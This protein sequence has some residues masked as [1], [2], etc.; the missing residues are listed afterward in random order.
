MAV[1]R[2]HIEMWS[3]S[4]DMDSHVAGDSAP[5]GVRRDAGKGFAKLRSQL[6][7]AL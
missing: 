4:M 7:P 2:A 6:E 1:V 3:S 5:R